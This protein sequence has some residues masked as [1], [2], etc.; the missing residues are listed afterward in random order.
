MDANSEVAVSAVVLVAGVLA[1]S[2]SLYKLARLSKKR[3]DVMERRL[4][5]LGV[6]VKHLGDDVKS[7]HD[8]LKR[9]IEAGEAR[10]RMED[11]AAELSM[12]EEEAAK[13]VTRRI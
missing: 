8:G 12:V 3:N 2:H 10:L 1:F 7:L 6:Y 11:A 5:D 9:K 13:A 4:E